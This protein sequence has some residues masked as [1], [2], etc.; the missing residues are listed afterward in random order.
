MFRSTRKFSKPNTSWH[1]VGKWYNKIVGDFGHYYHQHV[2]IPNTLKLL[3]I[4]NNSSLLDLAC[5][6]G[7][8]SRKLPKS[9]F[10]LGIDNAKSLI[11]FAQKQA[12]ENQKFIIGN[13]TYNLPTDK[14]DF[15]HATIILALQNIENPQLVLT[16]ACKHLA[17]NGKLVI[18]LNHPCFRIP[19]MSSWQIDEAKKMEYRRIDKYLTP[20]QIPINMAPS[21]GTKASMTWSF[22]YPLSL[23]FDFLQKAGFM[24]ENLQEWTSD[25]KS[26]GRVAKMENR[27]RSEFPMFLAIKAVKIN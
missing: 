2:I 15:T 17:K 11:E 10:Y 4:K 1:K 19:R 14:I 6:Q 21:R 9:V 26:E 12:L 22:H 3:D 5:G 20:T 7:V 13:V 23:Y 18:V 27:S 8:L 16:Q 24:I 25:K